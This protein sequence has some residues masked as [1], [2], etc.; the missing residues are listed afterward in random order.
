MDRKL[1]KGEAN[2]IEV[3]SASKKNSSIFFVFLKKVLFLLRKIYCLITF[4]SESSETENTTGVVL[5]FIGVQST[6]DGIEDSNCGA[7]H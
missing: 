6:A 4:Q 7:V 1:K 2:L 3:F 5:A